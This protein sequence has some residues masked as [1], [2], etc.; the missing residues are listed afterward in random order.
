MLFRIRG[1]YSTALTSLLMK[2]GHEPT[3][4]SKL[5]ASRLSITPLT[6]PPH[7]DIY[8]LPDKDGVV[9]EGKE[10]A[11]NEALSIIEEEL[12][13][14]FVKEHRARLNAVYKGLVEEVCHDGCYVDLG[15]FR[16][17]L[18]TSQV[19]GEE[20]VVTVV[21]CPSEIPVL[22]LGARIVGDYV[23]LIQGH[24]VSLSRGLLKSKRAKELMTL[25]RAVKPHGWGG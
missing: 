12:P 3:Q 15:G 5:I 22:S 9:L 24:G 21:K 7:L 18:P 10:E 17:F 13:D 2:R 6:L 11:V 14:V 8:D 16:G 20:V 25:G 23:K 1:I 4:P 19:K